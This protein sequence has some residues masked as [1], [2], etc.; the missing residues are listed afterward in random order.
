MDFN[1]PEFLEVDYVLQA[2]KERGKKT[3]IKYN[4]KAEKSTELELLILNMEKTQ[5]T[6][7]RNQIKVIQVLLGGSKYMTNI[8]LKQYGFQ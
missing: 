5:E 8:V 7:L 4:Q 2:Y 6:S 1:N 3:R